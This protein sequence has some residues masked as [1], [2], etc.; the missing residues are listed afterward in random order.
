MDKVNHLFSLKDDM[1]RNEKLVLLEQDM[2]MKITANNEIFTDLIKDEV[3][4]L[5][6]KADIDKSK[7]EDEYSWVNSDKYDNI[8]NGKGYQ[9]IEDLMPS[10]DRDVACLMDCNCRSEC[11]CRRDCGCKNDCGCKKQAG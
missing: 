7:G 6:N 4:S 8:L 10:I 1:K 5:N 11:G 9:T 3:H 2:N